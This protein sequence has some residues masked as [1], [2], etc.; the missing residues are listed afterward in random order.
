MNSEEEKKKDDEIRR[1]QKE[2]AAMKKALE[3]KQRHKLFYEKLIELA[4]EE[5]N[6]E[7]IPKKPKPK[8]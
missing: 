3:T 8:K 6:I 7:I 1:L 4:E 2:L 5:F